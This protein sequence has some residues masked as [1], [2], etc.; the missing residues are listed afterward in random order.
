[1]P[2]D[3]LRALLEDPDALWRR[4]HHTPIKL[5][6][7][8]LIVEA[9]L[10]LDGCP[11]RVIY[12]RSQP[13]SWWK[14]WAAV[15]RGSRAA[16]AWR[17][18]QG[19]LRRGIATAEPVL[20]CQS[21]RLLGRGLGYLATRWIEDSTNLHLYLWDLAERSPDER[22][23]RVR[24]LADSLGSMLGRMHA[25]GVTNRDLKALNL[26]VVEQAEGLTTYL[27][28]VDGVRFCRRA[29]DR[30]RALDLARLATSL[31]M[32]PWIT[33]ADRCRFLRSYLRAAPLESSDRTGFVRLLLEHAR[34]IKRRKARR[35]QPIA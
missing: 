25:R 5:S 13:T 11:T 31:D 29:S 9:L 30:A 8:S 19:L 1:V 17:A 21:R 35:G 2:H 32:H 15:V 7:S 18:A 3:V 20:L 16:R 33:S 24:Q 12:K 10:T 6:H 4:H 22:G 27:V 34:N 23:Q 26:V 28:D 14:T